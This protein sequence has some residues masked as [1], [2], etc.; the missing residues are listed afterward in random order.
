VIAYVSAFADFLALNRNASA[1]TVA[2]YRRDVLQYLDCVA[3]VKGSA[4][5]QLAASDLDLTSVRAFM[6]ELH[7]EGQSRASTARK[8]SALRAFGRYL[9]REHVVESEPAML[10]AAPKR[11]QRMPAHLTVDEMTKLLDM[12]DQA[13]PLGRRDRAILELFYASGLRLSE[14][15]GLDLEDLNLSARMVRVMGKGRK[16]RLVPFNVVSRDALAAWLKDRAALVRGPGD[17]VFVNARGSRLTG[18]SVQ[19]LVARYVSGCSTRFGISPHALRHSF[20]THLLQFGADLRAIQELL[21]HVQLA[22]TQRYT[23]VDLAQLQDA[24]RRAHPRARLMNP[25]S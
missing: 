17:P 15:V 2:A 12:P 1:H 6:A 23:H 22:T 14:L 10:A 24:Y 21:G 18:R 9:R 3:R 25:K 5:E 16:E 4:A 8:L 13:S 7:K 19:R 11:E 20:A